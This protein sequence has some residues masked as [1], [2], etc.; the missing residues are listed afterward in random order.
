MLA[1]TSCVSDVSESS[2]LSCLFILPAGGESGHRTASFLEIG[3]QQYLA[4][5]GQRA[6][7][8]ISPRRRKM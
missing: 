7:I 4:L 6:I 8:R 5:K 2:Y 3:A 1:L